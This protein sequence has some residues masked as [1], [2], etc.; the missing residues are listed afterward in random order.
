M[1]IFNRSEDRLCCTMAQVFGV[2]AD[3][4]SEEASP[5]NVAAWD[6]LNH[7]KLAVALKSEFDVDLSIEHVLQMRTVG[8]IRTILRQYGAEV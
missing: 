4:L 1:I 3:L 6:S 2:S 7:L 8:M 5:A